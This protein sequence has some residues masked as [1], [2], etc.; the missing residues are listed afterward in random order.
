MKRLRA[1]SLDEIKAAHVLPDAVAEDLYE[2][3]RGYNEET[4]TAIVRTEAELEAP[5]VK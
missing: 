5:N 3:L 4:E 1:A 2:I